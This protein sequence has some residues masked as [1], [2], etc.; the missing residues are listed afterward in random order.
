MRFFKKNCPL[1]YDDIGE[2]L[3]LETAKNQFKKLNLVIFNLI[4]LF[5]VV[6]FV[7]HYKCGELCKVEN[8]LKSFSY[9]LV[10]E[11]IM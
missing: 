1:D 4:K 6:I 7:T 3:I 8:I 10:R 5:S 11:K 2:K 9:Q